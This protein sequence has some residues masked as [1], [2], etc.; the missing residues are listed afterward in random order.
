MVIPRNQN[1]VTRGV[2]DPRNVKLSRVLTIDRVSG[3]ANGGVRSPLLRA[4]I[5]TG[6]PSTADLD[7]QVCALCCRVHVPIGFSRRF[8]RFF[9]W[10]RYRLFVLEILSGW[11]GCSVF[12]RRRRSL[13]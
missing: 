11:R 4:A 9:A 10:F 8:D 6:D 2:L 13:C 12:A 3:D 5:G 1:H 7:S